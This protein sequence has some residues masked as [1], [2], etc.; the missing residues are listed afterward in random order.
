MS[1]LSDFPAKE[2]KAYGGGV[3]NYPQSHE[4]A[5]PSTAV[6]NSGVFS[7]WCFIKT[8]CRHCLKIALLTPPS[9]RTGEKK[10]TR[11]EVRKQKERFL[12]PRRLYLEWSWPLETPTFH[13]FFILHTACVVVTTFAKLLIPE[14]R[15][16]I[17]S[18]ILCWIKLALQ[19]VVTANL[20]QPEAVVVL[21]AFCCVSSV[22]NT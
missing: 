19:V 16:E 3:Q 6:S 15:C 10:R 11:T 22:I 9:W 8:P 17:F 4:P 13:C 21:L 7:H 1:A 12:L 18:S 14:K 5:P 2:N 20:T